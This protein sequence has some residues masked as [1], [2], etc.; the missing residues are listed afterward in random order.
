MLPGEQGRRVSN[1]KQRQAKDRLE[2]DVYRQADVLRRPRRRVGHSLGDRRDAHEEEQVNKNAKLT[3][4]EY[5]KGCALAEGRRQ[6]QRLQTCER[7]YRER[8]V[9]VGSAD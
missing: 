6:Q 2:D 7:Q 3:Q 9:S 5:G 8:E 1:V 4:A